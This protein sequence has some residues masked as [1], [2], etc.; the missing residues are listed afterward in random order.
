M[1]E[2]EEKKDVLVQLEF[3]EEIALELESLAKR[4]GLTV[5]E[6]LRRF[7]ARAL[8]TDMEDRITFQ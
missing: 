6:L 1:S 2:S 4:Q 7:I 3:P 8:T 5:D